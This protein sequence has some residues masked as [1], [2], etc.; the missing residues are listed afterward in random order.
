MAL[1]KPFFNEIFIASFSVLIPISLSSVFIQAV[2]LPLGKLKQE[3][4]AISGQHDH[5]YLI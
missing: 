2:I 3:G 1:Q 4:Q 5:V